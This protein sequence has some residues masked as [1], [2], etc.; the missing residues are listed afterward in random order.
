MPTEGI[1]PTSPQPFSIKQRSLRR[2]RVDSIDVG[3]P[4]TVQLPPLAENIEMQP[5]RV[6]YRRRESDGGGPAVGFGQRIRDLE[7]ANSEQRKVADDRQYR[8]RALEKE[9]AELKSQADSALRRLQAIQSAN[10]SFVATISKLERELHTLK[11]EHSACFSRISS[12]QTRYTALLSAHSVLQTTY[13]DLRSSHQTLQS[14][15]SALQMSHSGLLFSNAF[16]FQQ[17]PPPSLPPPPPPAPISPVIP[18]RQLQRIKTPSPISS[19][20]SSIQTS[21]PLSPVES[22]AGSDVYRLKTL[23]NDRTSELTSLQMFLSKHDEWSGA[24]V[25]QA[26]RDLNGEI[27]RLASAVSEQFVMAGTHSASV[28]PKDN[29][30]ENLL[31]DVLGTQLYNLLISQSGSSSDPSLIIQY[32]IQAWQLWCCTQILDRF[33]FGLPDDVERWLAGVWEGMKI[34]GAHY[35]HQ[36]YSSSHKILQNFNL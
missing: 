10:N 1:S 15:C 27:A 36:T 12:T 32:A 16:S 11:I 35:C 20:E 30:L 3:Q 25:V 19:R 8:I 17:P 14:S 33:C 23:L 13:D 29:G 21:P 6:P 4:R 2:V 26:V 24:Q 7:Y 28:S 5:V 34:K 22:N 9:N 18:Q 31:V